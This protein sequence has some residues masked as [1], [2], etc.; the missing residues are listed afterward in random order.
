MSLD[1]ATYQT[2]GPHRVCHGGTVQVDAG[3][4]KANG[5]RLPCGGQVLPSDIMG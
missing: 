2:G 5:Q 4:L 3:W 1:Q